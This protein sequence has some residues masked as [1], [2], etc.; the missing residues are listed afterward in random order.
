V[1]APL[2]SPR[3]RRGSSLIEV[4]ISLAIMAIVMVGVLQM[5]SVA[6]VVNKGAAARTHMQFRC[7]QVVENLR[8]YY[9]LARRNLPTPDSATSATGGDNTGI[10]WP[11]PVAA[12]TYDLPY[13]QTADATR[14]AYWGPAGANVMETENG[15]YKLSYTIY[16]QAAG[17][18][19]RNAGMWIIRVTAVPTDVVSSQQYF[20][21]G[22]KNAKRIDYVAEF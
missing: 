6:L 8:Y 4:L 11:M 21:I 10:P 7:Q 14:W 3:A 1:R 2:P 15:P 9:F 22:P 12:T 17:D 13:N 18:D 16:Q 20:G 5:F 19:Q